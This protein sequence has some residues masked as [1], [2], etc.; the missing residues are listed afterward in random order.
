MRR[1]LEKIA[2]ELKDH[3]VKLE[4]INIDFDLNFDNAENFFTFAGKLRTWLD[5]FELDC[6]LVVQFFK[7][8]LPS[9]PSL[10]G[11]H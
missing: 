7:G 3:A 1:Y 10:S 8:A 6:P 2:I 4:F 5:Q 11:C 9:H